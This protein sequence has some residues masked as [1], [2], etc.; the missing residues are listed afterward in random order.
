MKIYRA[1]IGNMRKVYIFKRGDVLRLPNDIRLAKGDIHER[2]NQR[3]EM[4]HDIEFLRLHPD[5]Q[6]AILNDTA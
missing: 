2:I 1:R 4:F 3:F 6:K 5:C